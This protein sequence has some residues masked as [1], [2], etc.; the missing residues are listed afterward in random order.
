MRLKKC[1]DLLLAVDGIALD[2]ASEIEL[3]VV[4][5]C[6][7]ETVRINGRVFRMV[8][9]KRRIPMGAFGDIH[10][11][12]KIFS[13]GAWYVLEGIVRSGARLLLS[14]GY[15]AGAL[16]GL[17]LDNKSLK[18][19]NKTLRERVSALEARSTGEEFL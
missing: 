13:G 5:A 15:V 14:D 10:N 3:E 1:G 18:D 12:I 6:G 19:E 7:D 8:S 11:E 17:L 16:A 2:N 9:G 4:D